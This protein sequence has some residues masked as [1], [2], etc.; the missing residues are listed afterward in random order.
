MDEMKLASADERKKSFQEKRKIRT[1]ILTKESEAIVQLLA[2]KEGGK[3]Q[4]NVCPMRRVNPLLCSSTATRVQP[5]PRGISR[6]ANVARVTDEVL[7]FFPRANNAVPAGAS[8]AFYPVL[9]MFSRA[10]A[11][12]NTKAFDQSFSDDSVAGADAEIAG[13]PNESCGTGRVAGVGAPL[14]MAACIDGTDIDIGDHVAVVNI[15]WPVLKGLYGWTNSNGRGLHSYAYHRPGCPK[16]RLEDRG[17]TWFNGGKELIAFLKNEQP[18]LLRRLVRG[19]SNRSSP[20]TRTDVG[21]RNSVGGR[22]GPRRR[23]DDGA[24]N[25][26]RGQRF[27]GTRRHQKSQRL[28]TKFQRP[29]G[30]QRAIGGVFFPQNPS[31]GVATKHSLDEC[32]VWPTDDEARGILSTYQVR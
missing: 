16:K 24:Q 26:T 28:H 17:K 1:A 21:T 9:N 5:T 10:T 4:G 23:G 2:G 13:G 29:I 11:Y 22:M 12:K 7:D 30:S 25:I 3:E 27:T 20:P 32:G 8:L 14:P 6:P 31:V 15:I 19:T 18:D